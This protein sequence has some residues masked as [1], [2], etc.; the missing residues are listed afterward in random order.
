MTDEV[1]IYKLAWNGTT[2]WDLKL[3][4]KYINA[5]VRTI[6]IMDRKTAK[7]AAILERMKGVFEKWKKEKISDA[8]LKSVYKE[9]EEILDEAELEEAM[10]AEQ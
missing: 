8:N 6:R 7:G 3:Q 5:L 1:L 10:E 9:V 2:T 4:S